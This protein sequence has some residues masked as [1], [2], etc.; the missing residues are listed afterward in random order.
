MTFCKRSAFLVK[1]KKDWLSEINVITKTPSADQDPHPRLKFSRKKKEIFGSDWNLRWT[2][3]QRMC[4]ALVHNK[5][6]EDTCFEQLYIFHIA[7]M[8]SD[9]NLLPHKKNLITTLM[10]WALLL[11]HIPTSHY[12]NCFVNWLMNYL[13]HSWES[14][15]T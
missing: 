11:R 14:I 2:N 13:S 12:H 3:W 15:S 1:G 8:G 4:C 6:V 7:S 5:K 9:T 10:F